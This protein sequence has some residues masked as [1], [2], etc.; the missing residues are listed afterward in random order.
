M[1]LV[2]K[3]VSEFRVGESDGLLNEAVVQSGFVNPNAAVSSSRW[4][5]SKK[6]M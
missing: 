6:S 2:C 1:L 5:E 4:Q 3:C